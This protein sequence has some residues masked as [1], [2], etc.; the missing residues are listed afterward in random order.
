MTVLLHRENPV[1]ALGPFA[2]IKYCIIVS[3]G[4]EYTNLWGGY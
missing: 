1:T 3:I 2:G 4:N